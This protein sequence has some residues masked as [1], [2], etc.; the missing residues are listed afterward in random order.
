MSLGFTT[1]EFPPMVSDGIS[2]NKGRFRGIQYFYYL[3]ENKRM[4]ICYN[5]AHIEPRTWASILASVVTGGTM[6]SMSLGIE[7]IMVGVVSLAGGSLFTVRRKRKIVLSEEFPPGYGY[8]Y[9]QKD[10]TNIHKVYEKVQ[11][12]EDKHQRNMDKK[13]LFQLMRKYGLEIKK[14]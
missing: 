6:L 2:E 14:I 11:E 12:Y 4:H 1:P 3:S 13:K 8:L 7:E 5:Y 9:S 10:H